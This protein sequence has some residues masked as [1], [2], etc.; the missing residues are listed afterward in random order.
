[1]EN[2]IY[3]IVLI[4]DVT[5][6]LFICRMTSRNPFLLRKNSDSTKVVLKYCIN[7]VVPAALL[8]LGATPMNKSQIDIEMAKA[9]WVD[10]EA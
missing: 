3:F 10:A 2:I 6:E 5:D 8:R 1:M 4:A 9:E 7:G